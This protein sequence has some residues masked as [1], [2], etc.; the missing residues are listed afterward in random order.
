MVFKARR[1]RLRSDNENRRSARSRPPPSRSWGTLP[2][3]TAVTVIEDTG[4]WVRFV[5]Q[6]RDAWVNDQFLTQA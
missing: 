4:D 6:G 1:F 2:R 3:G 5:Y